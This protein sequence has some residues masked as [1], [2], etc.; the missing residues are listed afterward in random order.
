[1][2]VLSCHLYTNLNHPGLSVMLFYPSSLA[3][4]ASCFLLL[5]YSLIIIFLFQHNLLQRTVMKKVKM[6]MPDNGWLWRSYNPT[7]QGVKSHVTASQFLIW[8]VACQKHH[9]QLLKML[10]PYRLL[11]L[12]EKVLFFFSPTNFPERAS[13]VLDCKQGTRIV[14][15]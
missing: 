12:F 8:T 5:L 10:V 6:I 3:F 2:R 7:I 13:D 11:T 15:N 1:M 14:N 9:S 4:W